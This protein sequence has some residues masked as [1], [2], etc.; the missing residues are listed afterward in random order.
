MKVYGNRVTGQVSRLVQPIAE[1]EEKNP[2]KK[3]IETGGRVFKSARYP[4]WNSAV[5]V[6]DQVFATA[7]EA[8]TYY[9]W[10]ASTLRNALASG[11]KCHGKKVRRVKC[12][13]LGMMPDVSTL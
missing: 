7:I 10:P 9:G 12:D 2:A 11:S 3:I 6:D 1:Q 13:E 4:Q 5:A 8:A